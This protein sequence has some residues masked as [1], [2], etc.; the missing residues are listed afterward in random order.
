MRLVSLIIRLPFG[1]GYEE[2]SSAS[3]SSIA[4]NLKRLAAA[5]GVLIRD[6]TACV[7]DRPRHARLVEDIPAAGAAISL[8][9]DAS[10]QA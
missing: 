6:I 3:H 10:L 9:G 5:K 1:L 7:L 2:G 4:E 8:I